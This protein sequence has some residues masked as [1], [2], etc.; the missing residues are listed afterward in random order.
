MNE[1]IIGLH[2]M[3]YLNFVILHLAYILLVFLIL[4]SN[5]KDRT[6]HFI[7]IDFIGRFAATSLE[8]S[9]VYSSRRGIE[10]C[11]EANSAFA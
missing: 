2:T 6:D 9:H 1:S 7:A 4:I 3:L 5:E 8:N 10:N 11:S